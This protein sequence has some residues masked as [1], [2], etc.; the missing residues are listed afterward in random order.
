MQDPLKR[1]LRKLKRDLK[2]A[3]AKKRRRQLQRDLADNPEE[4]HH[5]E[6]TFGRASSAGLNG[7]DQDATRRR[8]TGDEPQRHRDTEK[9]RE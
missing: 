8:G 5:S 6:P 2:R 4:A 1:Q 3:G 7:L 9:T